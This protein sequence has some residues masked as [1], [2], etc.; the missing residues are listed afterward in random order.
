MSGCNIQGCERPH[1]S[2]GYCKVH[3]ERWRIH[4]DPHKL[5]RAR[6]HE[7]PPVCRVDDCDRPVDAK[8]CCSTHYW[9]LTRHGSTEP[10][11]KS[12]LEHFWQHTV[13]TPNN[14]CWPWTGRINNG[15]G[16]VPLGRRGKVVGAHRFAYELLLGPIPEGLTLDHL[17]LTTN[18]VNP[19][20][21]DPV[22]L[23]EN[24]RRMQAARR[25][26]FA[27]RVI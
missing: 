21:L 6:R 15:Y 4:G 23:E 19:A 25:D 14:G 12:P 3:Y 17:C 20:H 7:T 16:V 18:C 11:R 24:V 2:R 22:S 27:S 1:R 5:L 10:P 26:G 13:V 8:G 9:R